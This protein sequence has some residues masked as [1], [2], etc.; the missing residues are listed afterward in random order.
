MSEIMLT[1][2]DRTRAVHGVVASEVWDAVVAALGAEP[3]TLEELH[4]AL[5]RFIHPSR[6]EGFFVDWASGVCDRSWTEGLC[7]VDLRARWIAGWPREFSPRGAA[8]SSTSAAMGPATRSLPFCIAEDWELSDRLTDWHLVTQQRYVERE[9]TPRIDSRA[10]LYNEVV[11]FLARE[12]LAAAAAD[13]VESPIRDIHARWLVTPRSDL[14]G[15]APRDWLLAKREFID[16]DLEDRCDQWAVLGESPP[17]I[18]RDS[19]AYQYAGF[20]IDEIVVYY[21]LV[22]R[23]APPVL[24]ARSFR[25]RNRRRGRDRSPGAAPRRLALLPPRR[26]SRL[27]TGRSDRERADA[28]PTGRVGRSRRD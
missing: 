22:P 15:Q 28:N 8:K 21:D 14:G 12:C 17:G 25:A 6:T 11:G 1:V 2:R 7:F 18:S 20:G 10:V 24:A 19:L 26:P 23:T 5:G 4:T 27:H 9:R 13:L 16:R 3:E